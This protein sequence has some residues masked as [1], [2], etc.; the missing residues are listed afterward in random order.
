MALGVLGPARLAAQDARAD[1]IEQARNEFD[2][3]DRLDLL[4]RAADPTLG[5]RDS[6]WAVGVFDLVQNL[7]GR[8]EDAA[9]SLWLRWAARHGPQ[10]TIDRSY[11]SPSTVAA[12]DRAVPAV[13]SGGGLGS[14]D[15]ST[16]WRW[17]SG[18]ESGA[19]GS[20]EVAAR[21]GAVPLAV[22]VE[23]RETIAGGGSLALEPGTYVLIAE[24]NGFETTRVTREVLPGV[25]TVVEFDLAPVLPAATAERVAPTL[26][27]IRWANEG[28]LICTNGVMARPGGLVLTAGG[29]LGGN[30]GLEVVTASGVAVHAVVAAR[31]AGLDLAVLR[32]DATQQPTLP[33]ATG[34]TDGQHAWSVFRSGCDHVGSARSRLAGWPGPPGGPAALSPGLPH[35]AVGSP[36]VDRA[37][38]IIGLVTG[39]ERVVPIGLAQPLLAAAAGDVAAGT[40]AGAGGG[41]LPWVWIGAGAAAVGVAAAVLGG[42][43]GP[44][45]KE[46]ASISVTWQGGAP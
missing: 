15:V 6:T 5:V 31:D 20:I 32:V 22:T 24:A 27:T 7:L 16:G 13:Q 9:G 2:E 14:P 19:D 25:T 33:A 21:D 44:P 18:F 35:E 12:W 8:G 17:P 37:G 29:G 1:L 39:P 23:G 34:I 26:V 45:G 40:Q 41:G 4:A 36:L 43:G 30:G 10:W 42:D 3:A 28:G 11:Y 46:T 38:G